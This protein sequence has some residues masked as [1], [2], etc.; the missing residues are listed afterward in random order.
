MKIV[1]KN[2]LEGEKLNDLFLFVEQYCDK[3]S[4]EGSYY[5]GVLDK[6]EFNAI[7]KEMLGHCYFEGSN[8]IDY[9]AIITG[10]Q[11]Y[12]INHPDLLYRVISGRGADS[13]C[14][15]LYCH[16]YFA[17]GGEV[18][19][20]AIKTRKKLLTSTRFYA[21]EVFSNIVFYA[22]STQLFIIYLG[23]AV[24]DLNKEQYQEFLK[25]DIEH[26][27]YKEGY[28][29]LTDAPEDAYMY[30]KGDQVEIKITSNLTGNYLESLLAFVE[31]Y[32]D[33]FLMSTVSGYNNGNLDNDE[34]DEMQKGLDLYY[35]HKDIES[36]S[37]SKEDVFYLEEINELGIKTHIEAEELVN[38]VMREGR[39]K[40]KEK[41]Y[42]ADFMVNPQ[43]YTEKHIDFLYRHFGDM[44]MRG[45][46][47]IY[48]C[49]YCIFAIGNVYSET[50]KTIKSL[51]DYP[52][53]DGIQF[54][55]IMLY[56]DDAHMFFINNKMKE[57]HLRLT[58]EQYQEFLQ[59]NIKHE[60]VTYD[61]YTFN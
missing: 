17:M 45:F 42:Y 55:D 8:K 3:F 57:A 10:P 47:G 2:D 60:K 34:F 49:C 43:S 19:N 48:C 52:W 18:Y 28:Y 37:M 41:D 51:F 53:F 61:D 38:K 59:L 1:I 6:D 33:K 25:L 31:R 46:G 16:C 9:E 22:G 26:E 54:K 27:E 56:S 20:G 29:Y 14:V 11:Q 39:E 4:M 40:M 23:L 30:Q 44:D 50:K 12:N 21:G 13:F 58:K 24:L 5:T 35:L 7:C 15:G 36:G 32:C